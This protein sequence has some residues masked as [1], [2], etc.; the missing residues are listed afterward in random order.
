LLFT[1]GSGFSWKQ[2]AP[3]DAEARE[4]AGQ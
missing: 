3:K 4:E 2:N 1:G